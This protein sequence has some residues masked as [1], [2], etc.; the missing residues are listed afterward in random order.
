MDSNF[1][2]FK[3]KDLHRPMIARVT[4][5]VVD[6]S[7]PATMAIN[8]NDWFFPASFYPTDSA[9]AVFFHVFTLVM[10][11]IMTMEVMRGRYRV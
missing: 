11:L 10:L 8:A 3:N 1:L 7:L 9:L 5:G 2:G 4:T 6:P